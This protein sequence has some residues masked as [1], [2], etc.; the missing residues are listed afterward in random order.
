[1][2]SSLDSNQRIKMLI[3][4]YLF[5]KMEKI[6]KMTIIQILVRMVEDFSEYYAAMRCNKPDIKTRVNLK[7]ILLRG[8]QGKE[9]N[10]H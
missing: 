9:A 8:K 6:R 10:L 2:K 4:Y 5:I 3:R 1:M 7:N